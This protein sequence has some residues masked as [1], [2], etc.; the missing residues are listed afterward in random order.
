[1]NIGRLVLVSCRGRFP[2]MFLDAICLVEL[3]L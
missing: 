3:K 1:M 2:V